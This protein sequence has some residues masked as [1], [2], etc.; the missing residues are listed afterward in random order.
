MSE[1][2]TYRFGPRP[3][4]G[5]ALGLA[6]GQLLAIGTGMALGLVLVLAHEVALGIVVLGFGGV[7]SFVPVRGRRLHAWLAPIC[8]QMIQPRG[9]RAPLVLRSFG[10]G[11]RPL[12]PDGRGDTLGW[13]LS[14]LRALRVAEV[15]SA[16]GPVGLVTGAG[17][18]SF[19]IAVCGRRFALEDEH[20]QTAMVGSW[21]QVLSACAAGRIRRLQVTER[22]VPD[23][24]A[25][26][27]RWLAE[28]QC[29]SGPEV[30]ASYR[31]HLEAAM[32]GAL[33]HEVYLTASMG[34]RG[35][36]GQGAAAEEC[37]AL[38]ELLRSAG[39]EAR[40]VGGRSLRLLLASMLHAGDTTRT[41]RA[42]RAWERS[43]ELVRTE[44]SCHACFEVVELPRVPVRADWTWPLLQGTPPSTSRR[45]AL[46]IELAPP[47]AGLRR[48]QRAVLSHEGDEDLRAKWGFRSGARTT[49]EADSARAREQELAS[50]FADARFVL[51]LA[52]SASDRDA[53]ESAARSAE[54]QAAAC[55]VELRR[56]YGQQAEALGASLPLARLQLAG[57]WS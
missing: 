14:G 36:G 45:W 51:L 20:V 7:W 13:R 43:W 32:T 16:A 27:L 19:T 25:A 42:V 34:G 26:Q 50:G 21:G 12:R 33:R 54:A 2:T 28:A 4:R 24:G 10:T 53:L 29:P 56:L 23:S 31:S 39:F 15:D 37:A 40:P 18:T 5:V 38:V 44:A 3:R 55:G 17:P 48:A 1:P 35:G 49:S 11:T 52:V 47:S 46:H 9:A 30:L 41:P 22:A 57:G 8:A 6:P